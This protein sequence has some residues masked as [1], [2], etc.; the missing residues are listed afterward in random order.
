M[1]ISK[2]SLQGL[3]VQPVR[4]F[5][6]QKSLTVTNLFLTTVLLLSAL[7]LLV[8]FLRND[9]LSNYIMFVVSNFMFTAIGLLVTMD[10]IEHNNREAVKCFLAYMLFLW[11]CSTVVKLLFF[12]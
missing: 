7:D 3:N 9:S 5:K 12:N 6:R 11:A 8:A 4:N 2:V 1:A 10:L